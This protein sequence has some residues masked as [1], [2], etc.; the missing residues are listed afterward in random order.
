[1]PRCRQAQ[2]GTILQWK[3]AS[4][5]TLGNPSAARP[6]GRFRPKADHIVCSD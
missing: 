4:G 3:L 2:G 5:Y 1:M 6:N